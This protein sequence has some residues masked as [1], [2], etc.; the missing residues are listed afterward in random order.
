M[1]ELKHTFSNGRMNK[2]LDERL[3]REGDYRDATNIEVTTSEGS[4]SGVVQTWRGNIKIN[5]SIGDATI[6]LDLERFLTA[7]QETA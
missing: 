6:Y 5:N 3:V 7:T 2:D 1:P 4:N